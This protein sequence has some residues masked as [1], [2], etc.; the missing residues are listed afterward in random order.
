MILGGI[1]SVIRYLCM[2]STA[3]R[4]RP[5]HGLDVEALGDDSSFALLKDEWEELEGRAAEDNI[6]LTYVW[7]HAWWQDLGTG[8]LDLVT[9]RDQGRLVGLAPTYH[10]KVGGFPAV[11]FGG[12]LEVSE[13]LAMLVA[14][15]YAAGVGRG[16]F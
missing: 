11:R 9:F 8:D 13:Y 2:T 1:V 7:Q 15:G 10:E 16:F 3:D 5:G 4:A 14:P 12:G 6:F